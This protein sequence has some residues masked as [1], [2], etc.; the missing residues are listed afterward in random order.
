MRAEIGRAAGRCARP[1]PRR[2]TSPGRSTASAGWP[3]PPGPGHRSRRRAGR[4]ARAIHDDEVERC[5][6][7]GAHAL[8]LLGR[9]ARILTHCNAGAL[10]T[11][12]YGTALG[13]VRAAHAADP[14]VRVL[15]PET[16]PLLQGSRLTAWELARDGIPHTLITDSM[17]AAMMAA[18]A[19][20]HVVVGADRIAANGDVANKI[21]T[22][23]LAVLAREHGIP[24]VVAAPTTTVD[25]STPTGREIPIEERSAD[26][27]RGLA[28]FGRAGA[29]RDDAGG[30]PGL[31]RH[32]RPPRRGHRHRGRRTP[33]AL[34]AHAAGPSRRPA[35]RRPAGRGCA[36]AA[37]LGADRSRPAS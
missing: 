36:T 26:E 16:R 5:R 25:L 31:R 17:A 8:P 4:R 24:V 27:V 12:G 35:P 19:V 14:S 33:A 32:P 22:Y 29:G 13:V 23:G 11:G 1:G 6:R 21:G 28:L 30:Q 7:I 10:A 2:S 34:R 18:G 9:G 20:S 37:R 3:T 15:V